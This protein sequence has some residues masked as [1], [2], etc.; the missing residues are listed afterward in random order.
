MGSPGATASR[1][2]AVAI[3]DTASCRQF[4]YRGARAEGGD[5]EQQAPIGDD[6]EN[7]FHGTIDRRQ[8]GRGDRERFTRHSTKNMMA[9][10]GTGTLAALAG[11]PA[12]EGA[13]VV[14]IPAA[15]PI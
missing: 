13:A 4:R 15:V 7:R 8:R 1:I 12:M 9:K 5:G 14:R 6:I 2:T 11:S 10:I 3:K